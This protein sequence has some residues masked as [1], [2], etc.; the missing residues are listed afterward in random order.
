LL[1]SKKTKLQNDLDIL[2]EMADQMDG[3]LR[4]GTLFGPMGPSRPTLTLGGYLM[5]EHRLLALKG[6]LSP[7]END[8]LLK[9]RQT[10][11]NTVMEWVVAT[12]NKAE[13]EI[14]AR[15]RQ[16]TE[17]I[18]ELRED[19]VR[20][21]SYYHSAVES[22]VMLTSLVKMLSNPP[23]KISPDVTGRIAVLDNAFY[24]LWYSDSS[25][26][27]WDEDWTIAYQSADYE[28]LYGKPHNLAIK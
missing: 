16:W 24:A 20:Y 9:A 26:F 21:W 8:R 10:F 1:G 6:T 15:L 3:Y 14:E 13:Q 12:E 7:A 2:E 17:T 25:L 28:F 4:M 27:V 23:F 11:E 19:A 18:R 5:R 22:R